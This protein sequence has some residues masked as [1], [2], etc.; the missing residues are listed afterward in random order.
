MIQTITLNNLLPQVFVDSLPEGDPSEVWMQPELVLHRGESVLIEAASGRGKTSLC[1]FLSGLRQD[2]KGMIM[3]D[4]KPLS[5]LPSTLLRRE[6]MALLF[7]E[8]HLFPE[9]TAVENVMLKSQLTDHSS[10]SDVRRMLSR[11]GLSN[12]LDTPCRILS[13]G[14]QQRVAFVR[15]L[16][17][18]ADFLLLD[19][20]VS[21]LDEEN[22]S[23]MSEMLQERQAQTG[24]GILV[25]SIGRRLPYQYDRILKL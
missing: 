8:L 18:P 3:V 5:S 2:Y 20:P 23:I 21:H 17:Q 9:L 25:T 12:R 11:L 22:G 19:E 7:Q 1:A 16:C 4:G 24:V 14:Q 13:I 6:V 10:E 15:M